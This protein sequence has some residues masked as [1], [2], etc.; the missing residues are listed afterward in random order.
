MQLPKLGILCGIAGPLFWLTVI[1][2]A[3]ANRPEFSH[4][5]DYISELGEGGSA[6][7]ALM[8]YVG[9][10]FTGFLYLVFAFTL[11][12][13]FPKGWPIRLAISLIALDGIGRIGAGIFPCDP[14]CLGNSLNQH[15]HGA[16]AT[17]GFVSGILAT[18][19]WG[20][21]LRRL[22]ET[23]RLAWYSIC[24]GVLA[25]VFLLLMSWGDNPMKTPGLFEHLASALLS[26]WLLVF[27]TC[28]LRYRP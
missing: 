13:I 11:L 26:I 7:E 3:G 20:I 25:M 12:G 6:T 22:R 10:E 17:V 15:L 5:T 21:M 8:R 4:A 27:S 24:T 1:G 2:I 16:F 28:I 14:G 19:A 18:L 23:Q 9:F